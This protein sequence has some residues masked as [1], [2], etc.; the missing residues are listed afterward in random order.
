MS[1]KSIGRIKQI[2]LKE[3]NDFFAIPIGVDGLLVDM[4]SQ[5]DLE[6]ELKLG[7]NHYTSITQ[8]ENT[9][10]ITEWYLSQPMEDSVNIN[11]NKVTHTCKISIIENDLN[12]TI[13]TIKLYQGLYK[14]NNNNKLLHTKTISIGTSNDQI[15]IN[16]KLDE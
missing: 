6:E 16:E 3:N 14:E 10:L 1:L 11:Q 9:T 5:L 7:G 15:I 4:L 12:D 2:R 13:I 8:S